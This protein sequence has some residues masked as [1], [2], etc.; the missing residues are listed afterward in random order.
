MNGVLI[1]FDTLTT[2]LMNH[3]PQMWEILFHIILRIFPPL[4]T[5]YVCFMGFMMATRN[6]ALWDDASIHCDFNT[7]QSKIKNI[8][9]TYN[10]Y[11]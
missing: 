4:F 5:K 10:I 1:F 11:C 8:I 6:N 7:L 3:K 2:T 9:A